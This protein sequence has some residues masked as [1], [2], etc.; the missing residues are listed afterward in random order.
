ME[1][2]VNKASTLSKT[3]QVRLLR[4]FILLAAFSVVFLY[5]VGVGVYQ[6][7]P[8]SFVKD[9]KQAIARGFA[10]TN[11][12]VSSTA[13][14]A[15]AYKVTTYR[16]SYFKLNSS[17][18]LEE[19]SGLP[20]RSEDMYRFERTINPSATAVV[21]M[22]PWVDMVSTHLNEF[23]GQITKS[24][25]M[26]LVKKA[27]ER[28]H[29]IIVLTNDPDKVDYNTNI[30]PE[31]AA[32]ASNSYS[33]SY[34]EKIDVLYHQDYDDESFAAYLRSNGIS[35][36][37]YTGFASNMCVIGRRMGMIPMSHHGFQL[38]FV[39]EAS[40]AVEYK[41]TWDNQ[42][43]HHATTEIISQWIAEIIDYDVFMHATTPK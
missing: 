7:P 17:G 6:W 10:T 25:I 20:F 19:K 8:F 12:S 14:S 24:R 30:Y 36:L 34:K 11:K 1:D 31:L 27:L 39:P 43:I 5:G 15:S 16:Q 40:A 33:G 21:V 22:D 42:T 37:I 13:P 9:A 26:P 38:F 18:S 29:P 3:T 23:Y 28:G 2:A 35:T 4:G 32:I 41:D